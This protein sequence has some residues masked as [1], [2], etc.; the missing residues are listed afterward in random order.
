MHESTVILFA[1]LC[2][3]GKVD[4]SSMRGLLDIVAMNF[5]SYPGIEVRAPLFLMGDVEKK[6]GN[7]NDNMVIWSPAYKQDDLLNLVEQCGSDITNVLVAIATEPEQQP[8]S[9]EQLS[10]EIKIVN[11]SGDFEIYYGQWHGPLTELVNGLSSACGKIVQE[12]G[13]TG[14]GHE[15][16][17]ATDNEA[18]LKLFLQGVHNGTAFQLG[19]RKNTFPQVIS[20]LA[21]SFESSPSMDIAAYHLVG[22]LQSVLDNPDLPVRIYQQSIKMLQKFE[23][24]PNLPGILHLFIAEIYKNLGAPGVEKN[25]RE[26]LRKSPADVDVIV[27][28][29]NYYEEKKLWGKAR[30]IYKNYL[31]SHG[32]DKPSHLVLHNLGT[33]Y[34]EEGQIVKAIDLWCKALRSD[35]TYS[36]A[37][38][39]LMNAYVETQE[40]G[41]MW[42]VFEEALKYPPIPW[43][44]YEHLLN[45]L[46][47]IEDFS[48]GVQA[49]RDY[50]AKNS[51]DRGAYFYL[52]LALY[53]LEQYPKAKDIL[54]QGL[55]NGEEQEFVEDIARLLLVLKFPN[56]E[57]KFE[58]CYQNLIEGRTHNVI[59][60]LKECSNSVE[61]FWPAWFLL[62]KVYQQHKQYAQA[63]H[64]LK[65]AHQYAPDN[66]QVVNELGI[67]AT[68]TNDYHYSIECFA[69]AVELSPFHPDYLSNLA[70]ELFK[71]GD[72]AHA[73][74]KIQRAL[75]IK[76]N[77]Q[78][79]KNI[80]AI[81]NG[82]MTLTP[83]GVLVPA[84]D[85]LRKKKRKK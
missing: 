35:R 18:A 33:I 70:L 84:A 67:V 26:S 21:Q 17:P 3:K 20:A 43:R 85:Q 15:K 60:F 23:K 49:L 19:L 7:V 47:K 63:L 48:S 54:Q 32:G 39:N 83:D 36:T 41:K 45:H 6:R 10:L 22:F 80:L 79:A 1:P 37:Y 76:P 82:K 44:C 73:K 38:V 29:G 64:A 25:I 53:R 77:D 52:G 72:R 5:Q 81:V 56:F 59:S 42:V 55:T 62:G 74:Q 13:I 34:A 69:K 68:L 78:V 2:V 51:E 12:L 50:I 65:Q 46:D 31:K 11:V 66:P 4:L 30:Q 24:M 27:A 9:G 14:E 58:R 61:A 40:Y 16:W 71:K 8:E 75:W 28:A 57:Q